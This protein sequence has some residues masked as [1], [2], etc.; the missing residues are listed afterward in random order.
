MP[1]PFD[2]DPDRPFRKFVNADTQVPERDDDIGKLE[3][4]LESGGDET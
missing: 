3:G 1:H 2:P 4:T